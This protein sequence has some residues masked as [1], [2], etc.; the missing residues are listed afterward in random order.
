MIVLISFNINIPL[1][2]LS[3]SCKMAQALQ[4]KKVQKL[5]T[6]YIICVYTAN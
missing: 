2:V 4:R 3:T 6:M 5:G 1:P